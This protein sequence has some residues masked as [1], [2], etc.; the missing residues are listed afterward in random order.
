MHALRPC[1]YRALPVTS[2]SRHEGGATRP[3]AR[4]LAS[5][6]AVLVLKGL[7]VVLSVAI[8][9]AIAGLFG[10]TSVTDAFFLARRVVMNVA[11]V[12]ERSVQLVMVPPLVRTVEQEGI[13]GLHRMLAR[14][15]RR[16]LLYAAVAVAAAFVLAP[17]IVGLV[18]P[19]FD[20]ARR[21]AAVLYFRIFVVTLPISAY[22]ALSGAMF[23]AVRRFALPV[24]ARLLPRLFSL[25][26]LGVLAATPL[27]LGMNL[28]AWAVAVGVVTM[29]AVFAIASKRLFA[30]PGPVA[31]IRAAKVPA[32]VSGGRLVALVLGQVHM[33]GSS[34]IDMGFA[35]LTAPGNVAILEFA[36]R[37]VN[38]GPGAAIGSVMVVYYTEFASALSAG[39][40]ARFRRHLVEA[41]R[42]TVFMV[43]PVGVAL[44][45]LSQDLVA[46][47]FA[48]GAF[49]PEAAE[50]T[51]RIVA[52][53]APLVVV[54]ALVSA[55]FAAIL[56]EPRISHLRVL[57]AALAG[58]ILV[59]A[60]LDLALIGRIGLLAVP[61]ASLVSSLVPLVLIHGAVARRT[62]GFL[63]KGDVA[64]FLAIAGA[65]AVMA[66]AM[67]AVMASGGA[68]SERG[69]GQAVMVAAAAIAG[70]GAYL[71]TSFAF[72]LPE[73]EVV[74]DAL[75]R[76]MGRGQ[77]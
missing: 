61:I 48:R 20:E 30:S 12:L 51:A 40:S 1:L 65:G 71:G 44:F 64:P 62:G 50:T 55:F 77:G 6:L 14:Y 18:A 72:R 67:T 3:S 36:Q 43:L 38:I 46:V 24:S 22:A 28:V 54:N 23:N 70:L 68:W 34:W 31:A 69:I 66:L 5:V 9:V 13:A 76:R 16:L 33:L 63:G 26:A 49:A 57:G 35:S 2:S 47:L 32:P 11:A 53:L 75:R 8:S 73:T 41:L 59:R 17:Q 27:A 25:V 21:A 58:S 37:L 19:G 42:M 56:A 60:G 45:L 10:A 52:L 15:T 29:G 7:G 74:R 4:S 39:D